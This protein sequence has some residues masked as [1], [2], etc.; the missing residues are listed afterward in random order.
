MRIKFLSKIFEPSNKSSII[1]WAKSSTTLIIKDTGEHFELNS[2]NSEDFLKV[3]YYLGING[4]PEPLFVTN[5]GF[6]PRDKEILINWLRDNKD[7]LTFSSLEKEI[8]C[9][10]ATLQKVGTGERGLADQWVKPLLELLRSKGVH[11]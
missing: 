5:S 6:D 4:L 2:H 8:G 11:L 7:F 1:D 9:K 3:G 10:N